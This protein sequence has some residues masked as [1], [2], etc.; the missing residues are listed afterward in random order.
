MR[1]MC[2]LPAGELRFILL[3]VIWTIL[4]LPV[5]ALVMFLVAVIKAD[6]KRTDA[7]TEEQKTEEWKDSQW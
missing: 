1:P 2:A 4:A 3:A 7:L 6:F 5:V